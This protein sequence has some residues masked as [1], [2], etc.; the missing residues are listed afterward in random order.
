MRRLLSWSPAAILIS[1]AIGRF[2]GTMPSLVTTLTFIRHNFVASNKYNWTTVSDNVF[3]QF[4]AR[5]TFIY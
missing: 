1:L 3:R 2:T 4:F 5:Q